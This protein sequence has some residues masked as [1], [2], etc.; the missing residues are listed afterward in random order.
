MNVAEE[1]PAFSSMPGFMCGRV[2]DVPGSGCRGP[3]WRVKARS[4]DQLGL[5]DGGC[6]LSFLPPTAE[7]SSRNRR[8]YQSMLCYVLRRQGILAIVWDLIQTCDSSVGDLSKVD[9]SEAGSLIKSSFYLSVPLIWGAEF[10]C[11]AVSAVYPA[12]HCKPGSPCHPVLRLWWNQFW[13]LQS[14]AA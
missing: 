4:F 9:I 2:F 6:K 12:T 14:Y 10:S 11:R 8:N 5:N 3:L 13:L 1:M 7:Y